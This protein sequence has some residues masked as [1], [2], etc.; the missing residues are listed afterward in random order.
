MERERERDIG[1]RK[2]ALDFED[3]NGGREIKKWQSI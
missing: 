2:Y 1:L 3:G